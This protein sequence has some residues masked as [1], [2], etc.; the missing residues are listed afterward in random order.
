MDRYESSPSR[1]SRKRKRSNR[2]IYRGIITGLLFIT[3]AFLLFSSV[4]TS[5]I[6][7]RLRDIDF[8]KIENIKQ[9]SFIYDI[10]NNLITSIYGVENR[11]NIPLSDIPLHVRNAFI[12]VE[13]I[14]FYNH[15][16]FDI[17]RIFG[18][19]IENIKQGRYAQGASTITQQVVRNGFLTQKKTINR[20]I[21]EIYLAYQ[22]EKKYSKDQILQMYLNLIYFGKGAY[23][24]EAASRLYFG[25]SAKDLTIAEGALLAGIP[26]NPSNY[27]PFIN[28]SESLA[29][30]DLVIDLMVS[31]GYLSAEEGSRIKQE[32]VS[33]S[34]P[35][36]RNYPY[37]FFMD[38][39]LEEAADILGVSEEELFSKG[40]RI[41][42]SLDT[43]LQEYAEKLYT[44]DELFPKSPS[45]GIPCES[46]LVV[47]DASS[48]EIR[49]LIGGREGVND[50][51]VIRKGLNR[52]TQARRQPGSTIKPLLIYAPAIENHGY[53][54]VTFLLDQES[55]FGNY[56]PSNY[57]GKYRGWITLRYALS[58]SINIPAIQVLKDIG[59]KNGISFAERLGIPFEDE[60]RE[61]LAI[62]LGGFYKGVTPI[63]LAR[64]YAV[65]A[66]NGKYKDYTTIRRIE[67]SYGIVVYE[68]KTKKSQVM[69][70]ETAFI[71]SD[72]LQD[73]VK[74]GTATKLKSLNI[75]LAAKTGTVQ[76]PDTS[77]F[78][79][80][81]GLND[82]WIAVY[83]PE[84]VV[85]IW[86]GYDHVS[87]DQYLPSDALG[88][89]RPAEIAK[90]IFEYLYRDRKPPT[91]QKP[92]NVV[93]AKLDAKALWE[94][95]KVLL[96]SPFTPSGYVI[97]EYFTPE[98]VPSEQ[99][100]YWAV[101]QTPADF[102]VT[103]NK[104]G[105]PVITFKP[106]D[107]FAVYN[108]YRLEEGQD[109]PL[110][111]YQIQTDTLD[112]VKW[113]DTLVNR[114]KKYGYYV[115]PIHPEVLV[116]GQ[117]LQGAPTPTLSVEIPLLPSETDTGQEPADERHQLP[118]TPETTE[119]NAE[120]QYE[121]NVTNSLQEGT[122]PNNRLQQ[123]QRKKTIKLELLD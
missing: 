51:N 49:A 40:Y 110:H 93:E 57:D 41:Y 36:S 32:K 25:K 92:L 67:N 59:I 8:S 23:G 17:K 89:I 81:N 76:L 87:K 14:R 105:L 45:S 99:S 50:D 20:K 10:D 61:H 104:D 2:H 15:R 94:E 80:I 73:T 120:S 47:L 31:N 75:P 115:V 56:K 72:I 30:K 111:I 121:E 95:R 107:A 96:A 74:S 18:S 68:S 117:P 62:G 11:I 82:S 112:T 88:G 9:S 52:A 108:I 42:T 21:Q 122:A 97:T 116:E 71:I 91:F 60:D 78:S 84:Y 46:A 55:Q 114:G 54:P 85:I 65:L 90:H 19:L 6:I 34:P 70:E 103:L 38:M 22:L 13:D 3:A 64:A 63:E 12:A 119:P 101:P 44:R 28:L 26:K 98:T 123:E 86:M 58:H 27:S 29:R 53:T 35:S 66:D 1:M 39:V 106:M 79:G 24:I 16:G 69:R 48:G 43:E 77:E 4:Y 113:T 5:I 83:N 7:N 33:L 118:E 37:R 109:T 100:H 102:D